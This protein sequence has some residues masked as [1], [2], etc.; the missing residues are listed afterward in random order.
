MTDPS[1]AIE[2]KGIS[3]AF[4]PV[5]VPELAVFVDVDDES[6]AFIVA[7]GESPSADEILSHCAERL[8]S[9]KRPA[10]IVFL[11]QIPRTASGK[12]QKHILRQTHANS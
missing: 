8:A 2:L 9:Y 10:R 4:G 12:A 1:F 11:D 7:H 6:V 3:K 5:I